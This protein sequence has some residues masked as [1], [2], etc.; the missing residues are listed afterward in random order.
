[1]GKST[2]KT[3]LKYGIIMGLS[4]C[5]YT[6]LMWLTKLDSTYLNIGQ[7]LD[8]LIILLPI[9]VIFKAIGV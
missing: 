3:S 6:I 4:F 7:Y 5:L 9:L 1:M 2:I 8:M